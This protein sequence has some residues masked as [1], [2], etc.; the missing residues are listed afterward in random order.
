[1]CTAAV[2]RYLVVLQSCHE[3]VPSAEQEGL[4][5]ELTVTTTAS[6]DGTLAD[7]D[8]LSCLSDH[9]HSHS[10]VEELL[11]FIPNKARETLSTQQLKRLALGL[12]GQLDEQYRSLLCAIEEIRGLI[13]AEVDERSIPHSAELEAFCATARQALEQHRKEAIAEATLE[14]E[15]PSVGD[16][17]REERQHAESP[18]LGEMTAELEH[19]PAQHLR[20]QRRRWADMTSSDEEE[21]PLWPALSSSDQNAGRGTATPEPEHVPAE[22]VRVQRRRW[23]DMSSDEG[24]DQLW[25]TPTSSNQ[26]SAPVTAVEAA[27]SSSLPQ[28][29]GIAA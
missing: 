27:E 14:S 16:S 4:T 2:W 6:V 28:R 21:E 15:D 12:Q 19:P 26:N 5:C 20:V 8:T 25:F 9:H 24:E 23:A 22:I 11:V 7:V 18:F 1:M 29:P 10:E 3:H 17:Q 13:D